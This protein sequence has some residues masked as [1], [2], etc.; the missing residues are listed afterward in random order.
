MIEL[1]NKTFFRV[2]EVADI[3]Q[4]SIRTIRR[5]IDSEELPVIRL[6]GAVRVSR[7]AI[8]TFSGIKRQEVTGMD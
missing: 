6:R 4:V 7:D 3:F 2:D 8:I 5:M 1:P